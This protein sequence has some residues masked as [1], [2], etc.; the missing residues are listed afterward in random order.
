MVI[1]SP[2]LSAYGSTQLVSTLSTGDGRNYY[3]HFMDGE[4]EAQEGEE[5][6]PRAD[7]SLMVIDPQ[8]KVRVPDPRVSVLNHSA[9][10]P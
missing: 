7:V 6:S 3:P 8:F 9:P 4:T 10:G 1:V 2:V 5:C